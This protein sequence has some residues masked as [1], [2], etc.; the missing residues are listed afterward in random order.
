[1]WSRERVQKQDWFCING[2][3]VACFC[4]VAASSHKSNFTKPR[5]SFLGPSLCNFK[6]YPTRARWMSGCEE[7]KRWESWLCTASSRTASALPKSI[8]ALRPLS[9]M[10]AGCWRTMCVRTHFGHKMF[11]SVQN[12][13]QSQKCVQKSV[14]KFGHFIGKF[15]KI[16]TLYSKVLQHCS[17][18]PS[19]P[20]PSMCLNLHWHVRLR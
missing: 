15:P 1:M 6:D 3:K 10:K 5:T 19:G 4:I 8:F 9:Y 12:C 16:W 2:R 17:W 7:R 20:S 14:Q 13:V 11:I 18:A